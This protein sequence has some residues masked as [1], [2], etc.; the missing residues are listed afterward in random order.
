MPLPPESHRLQPD[1]LPT[2]FSAAEIREGCPAGR[3][4]RIREEAPGEAPS[5]RRIRF[6]QVDD[7]TASQEFQATD[8]DGRPISEPT[9]RSS[10]WLDLQRHASQPAT[11]TTVDETALT[12]PFGDW[13]CWRYTVR[14]PDAELRF[15]F[16]KQ[17]PGMPVQ[18]EEW[19]DG[20]LA[21]RSVMIANETPTR[22]GRPVEKGESA[23]K[24]RG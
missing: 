4:I 21:G 20:R 12:L 14:T 9:V 13:A 7:W 23:S 3:T 19:I 2:P 17:L 6:T 15:W 16:A 18:V 24:T 22:W 5:F 10:T 11:A 8:A 1:H